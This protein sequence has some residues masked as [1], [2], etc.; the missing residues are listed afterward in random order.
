MSGDVLNKAML[1][2]LLG[3]A[4]PVLIHL[5]NRRRDPVIDW[6]AMQF[7]DLGRRARRRIRL[8]ELLL[9]LARMALLALVALALARPF[10]MPA[11][12][13]SPARGGGPGAGADAP[14]RD[15][16]LVVDGSDSMDRRC[17]GTTPRALAVRWARQFVAQLR[18][19]D[20]VAVLVAGERVGPL[21]D[22]PSFDRTRIDA[23]LAALAVQPAR[24]AGRATC[25]PPWPRR[26]ACSSGP[27]TPCGT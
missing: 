18:P 17:G 21:I 23:V 4:L 24:R 12:A 2:G 26:F 25:P 1:L 22:P 27:R 7:L 19:G 5:L 3:V 14:P 6:G 15:V 10:W 8:T 16:V 11:A 20:S 13:G 9:M